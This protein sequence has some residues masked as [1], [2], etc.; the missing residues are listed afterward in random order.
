VNNLPFDPFEKNADGWYWYA[1]DVRAPTLWDVAARKGVDVL[2]V[3]WPVTVGANIRYNVPQFWRAKN[4]E[5]EKVLCALAT[6]GMCD[7]LR[8]RGAAVPLDQRTD[9]ERARAAAAL[10]RATR[11]RLAFVYL[12]DLDNVE[13]AS[14]PMSEEAFATLEGI[15][16]LLG[17]VIAA[18][19]EVSRYTSVVVV[20]DHG[21][22]PIARETR[23]NV[24][25]RRAG[26]VDV[27]ADGKVRAYEA[28]SSKAGGVAAVYARDEAVRP[29]VRAVLEDLVRDPDSGV[30]R[31]REGPEVSALGGFPGAMFVLEA[32]DGFLFS[33]RTEE[34]LTAPSKYKG[35]HGHDPARREM[36]TSLVMW[37]DGVR[38]G[39]RVG[40][41]R[42]V[43]VAPTIARLAQL[44][45]GSTEGAAIEA[46]LE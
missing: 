46:A 40:D 34:P 21:F 41:V 44:D 22:V 9:V 42:M 25:L 32:A 31:V 10:L 15:D 7:A 39:A 1:A 14:G 45:L 8:A 11:P 3:S 18:A 19:R 36:R 12:T 35:A 33:D 20:S 5:D 27:G 30:A 26:L 29:R 17:E 13:H 24:A 43:D 37:G 16:G 2:N 6:P 28:I 4:D 23:P 38:A